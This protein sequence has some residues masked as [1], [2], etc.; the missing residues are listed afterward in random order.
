MGGGD[1]AVDCASSE[2]FEEWVLVHEQYGVAGLRKAVEG[3]TIAAETCQDL[4]CFDNTTLESQAQCASAPSDSDDS[5][6]RAHY[7]RTHSAGF[8]EV[9]RLIDATRN[10][11]LAELNRLC[12]MSS[13][14]DSGVPL[15]AVLAGDQACLELLVSRGFS[16]CQAS[17]QAAAGKGNLPMLQYL[18]AHNC[19]WTIDVC[20]AAAYGGHA[21]L[22]Q[23]A[24][25]N[26]AP[27]HKAWCVDFAR[28]HTDLCRWI[29]D[30]PE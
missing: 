12:S 21:E 5:G 8:A 10:G 26:G 20:L 16:L 28:R 22:L 17:T 18:R 30:Q 14:L 6:D 27:W 29:E 2:A 4:D 19:P 13:C 9:Q 24:R 15:S 7:M 1:G 25:A 23:W 3:L 11:N